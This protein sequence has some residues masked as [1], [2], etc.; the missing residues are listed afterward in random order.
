MKKT[1]RVLSPCMIVVLF[2]WLLP[3]GAFIGAA[4]EKTACGGDRAFH[5]CT[6]GMKVR[7]DEGPRKISFSN[8]SGIDKTNKS[9]S[10]GGNDFTAVLPPSGSRD[11]SLGARFSDQLIPKQ[12]F[13]S[14]LEPV[15]KPALF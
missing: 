12:P 10:G 4:K 5:M 13:F 2:A 9:S 11:G 14:V 8:A 6:M 15:P 1:L 3:L 7:P